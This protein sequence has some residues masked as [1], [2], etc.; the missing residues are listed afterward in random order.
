MDLAIPS[1]IRRS[2]SLEGA[3][4]LPYRLILAGN[5]PSY[6]GGGGRYHLRKGSGAHFQQYLLAYQVP[7]KS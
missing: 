3:Q 2:G 5:I 7:A 1:Y 4:I 6:A